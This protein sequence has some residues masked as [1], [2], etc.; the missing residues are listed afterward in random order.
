SIG[1][2]N[3]GVREMDKVSGARIPPVVNQVQFSPFEY[4][5][6]LLDAGRERKVVI[7]S[8][9]SLGTGRHLSNQHVAEIARRIGRS[10]AQVLLRWCVQH[11]LIVIPKSS[12]RE[13]IA[14]NADIFDFTLSEPDMATLDALDRTGGTD[15]A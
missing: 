5:R 4:R 9:S 13:R 15:R 3:F 12:H 2:S 14:E 1:V 6:R 10:P 7:E 11:G 8:Y